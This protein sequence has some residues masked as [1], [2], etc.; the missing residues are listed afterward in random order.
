LRYAKFTPFVSAGEACASPA[1]RQPRTPAPTPPPPAA[2]VSGPPA[3]GAV[4]TPKDYQYR[5][6]PEADTPSRRRSGG[7]ARRMML[8]LL[9]A[10]PAAR[11]AGIKNGAGRQAE[12]RTPPPGNEAQVSCRRRR[13]A[14]RAEW[15]HQSRAA[16]RCLFQT[17]SA[18][19]THARL[20]LSRRRCIFSPHAA[21]GTRWWHVSG[22]GSDRSPVLPLPCRAHRLQRRVTTRFA[23]Q[24]SLR[25]A[26]SPPAAEPATPRRD[27]G[28]TDATPAPPRLSCRRLVS[29]MPCKEL[30]GIERPRIFRGPV[31][32]RQAG[33]AALLMREERLLFIERRAAQPRQPP[34]SHSSAARR[35]LFHY[36]FMR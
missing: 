7:S 10:E 29:T 2:A 8:T 17:P 30:A 20:D 24:T 9:Y 36:A 3:R 22:Q 25:C 27:E 34:P 15:T 32:A 5:R 6:P 13:A 11:Q 16:D 14:P 23:A 18:A 1:R 12:R 21:R 19:F 28:T 31:Q 4:S 33:A 35:P 26:C